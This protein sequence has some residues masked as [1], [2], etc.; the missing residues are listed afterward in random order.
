MNKA[1]AQK[2]FQIKRY[3]PGRLQFKTTPATKLIPTISGSTSLSDTDAQ[4]V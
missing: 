4:N 3:R 2:S 1:P